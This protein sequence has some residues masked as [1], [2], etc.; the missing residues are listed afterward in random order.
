MTLMIFLTLLL[1]LLVTQSSAG[2]FGRSKEKKEKEEAALHEIQLGMAGLERVASDPALL[3]QLQRDMMDPEMMEA[4]QK[5][6]NSKEFKKQMKSLEKSKHFK[7]ALELTQNA[8]EDP[9]TSAR[10]EAQM[11]KMTR[12]GNKVLDNMEE[13]VKTA[14]DQMGKNPA[15]MRELK[16]LM[17]NPEQLR[18][19][20]DDPSV[21]AYMDQMGDIMKDPAAAAQMEALKKQ[22][23][24]GGL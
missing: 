5:M 6:M 10:L 4:A 9:Q 19:M 12:D 15:M 20:M 23:S 13:T 7:D 11:E 16:N 14:M 22:F 24:A 18:E 21:R 8:L 3:A 17:S 2:L 1:L